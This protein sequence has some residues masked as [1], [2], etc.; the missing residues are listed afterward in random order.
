MTQVV[1]K[2]G[3]TLIELLVVIAIIALLMAVIIPSL[4]LAKKKAASIVCMSNTRQMSLAWYMYQ[5]ENDGK[6]MSSMMENVGA[7][8]VCR[9]AWIG[10][11]HLATDNTTSSL[12][13]IQISPPVTDEDEIRGAEKGKLHSYMENPDVYHCPAD[14]LRKGPDGTRLYVSYAIPIC[15][16]GFTNPTNADYEYQV[17]KFGRIT[18]PSNRYNFVESGESSRGNWTYGGYFIMA[19]PNFH[20]NGSYGMWS[21]LAISHGNSAVFGFADGHAE[22]HKWHDEVVFDHYW[23]TENTGPGGNYGINSSTDIGESEDFDWMIRGW[24]YMDK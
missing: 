11:P 24:A 4:G 23:A 3:F 12:T 7:N 8:R 13:M 20:G 16:N 21:P 9:E 22:S 15:L 18:S 2:R 17:R 6:L 10:Q 14:K 1:N 19:T 5:D